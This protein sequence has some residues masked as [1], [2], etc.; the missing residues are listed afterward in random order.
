MKKHLHISVLSWLNFILDFLLMI[1]PAKLI[2]AE[3]VGKSA[4]ANAVYAVL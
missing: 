4:L 3:F 1:I 2:A